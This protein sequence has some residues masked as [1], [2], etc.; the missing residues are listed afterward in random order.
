M[1]I[2][3]AEFQV[4]MNYSIRVQRDGPDESRTEEKYSAPLRSNSYGAIEQRALFLPGS[5]KSSQQLRLFV[6]GCLA[7]TMILV[8][9][10][11]R[12]QRLSA[13]QLSSPDLILD[14]GENNAAIL[15]GTWSS[16][17]QPFSMQSPARAIPGIPVITERP[18]NTGPGPA[19]AQ[20]IREKR[21]LPTNSWAENLL[22][23]SSL[24]SSENRVYQVCG[25]YMS[26]RFSMLIMQC[27]NHL[28]IRYPM[29]LIQVVTWLVYVPL[30]RISRHQRGVYANTVY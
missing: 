13:V 15:K 7:M 19:F 11:Y 16:I 12:N 23:G 30:G 5:R 22:I 4:I 26:K 10:V 2:C 9:A 28:N 18:Y 21:G 20:L 17:P 25:H 29:S 27:V 6:L 24:R 3:L 1:H 14:T 8:V